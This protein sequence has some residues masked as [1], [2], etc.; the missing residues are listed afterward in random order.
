MREVRLLPAVVACAG[1]LLFLKLSGL[2]LDGHYVLP[3]PVLGAAMAQAPA[4]A[5]QGTDATPG[6]MPPEPG[7]AVDQQAGSAM[8]L[9]AATDPAVPQ[10]DQQAATSPDVQPAAD[11]APTD[12]ATPEQ[13][14]QGRIVKPGEDINGAKAAVLERL[15]QRRIEL[16]TREKE[17]DMREALLNAA[18]ARIAARVNELKEIEARIA[19][20]VEKREAEKKA[21]LKGLVTMYE[22]MKPKDAARIFSEL[23][24]KVLV[25]VVEQM[26]ARKMAEVLANMDVKAAERLTL[27]LAAKSRE[28]SFPTEPQDLPKIE[29]KPQS[30]PQG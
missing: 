25:D 28:Q 26:N 20:A 17:L 21:Q 9:P 14:M 23:N 4:A 5:P 16:D 29:G 12:G 19:A 1:A 2:M 18:E 7:A 30:Q 8:E 22:T 15:G 24:L 27:A 10:A 3:M 6:E 13:A 11:A